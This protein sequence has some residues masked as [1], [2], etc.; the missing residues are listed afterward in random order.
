MRYGV[1]EMFILDTEK[2]SGTGEN[3]IKKLGNFILYEIFRLVKSRT[4]RW[5]EYYLRYAGTSK[6]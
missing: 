3:S 6:L 2:L 5:A 4:L 1:E